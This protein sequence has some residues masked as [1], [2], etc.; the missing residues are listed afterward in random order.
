MAGSDRTPATKNL[1]TDA[2]AYCRPPHG[3]IL[4]PDKDLPAHTAEKI[5]IIAKKRLP[6]HDKVAAELAPLIGLGKNLLASQRAACLFKHRGFL[7]GVAAFKSKFLD[8][9]GLNAALPEWRIVYRILLPTAPTS[10]DSSSSSSLAHV[11]TRPEYPD[12]RAMGGWDVNFHY[13]RFVARVLAVI[14]DPADAGSQ[15]VHWVRDAG[16]EDAWWVLFHALMYL[17][18]ETMCDRFRNA[19]LRRR[20]MA[21]IRS[22]SCVI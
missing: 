7:R 11:L 14:G 15:L 17:Q 22:S 18:L 21:M 4:H 5:R 9:E 20:V 1:G 6:D 8:S 3:G 2:D 12:L 19:P 16:P 10:S 13:G